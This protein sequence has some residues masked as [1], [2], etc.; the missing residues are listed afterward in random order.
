MR[1][2]RIASRKSDLALQQ[3]QWVMD[4]MK[5]VAP[6]SG[7]V[8]EVVP[9]VTKGDRILDVTLSKVGGKGLFVSEVEACLLN[10]EADMA[11]HSLKDVPADVAPGLQL[12][13]IP[14]RED[15]RDAWVSTSG[16][17]L[18]ELPAGSRVGTSSLRRVA[19]LKQVRPDLT[20]EPVRGNIG[21]RLGKMRDGQFDAI[22]LAAAGLHRMGWNDLVTAYLEP[23]VCIPAVG[24]AI[25]GVESRADDD[26]L[27][28][29]LAAMTDPGTAREATA[30]RTLLKRLN[31][32]CQVPIAGY[33]VTEKDGTLWLRGLVGNPNGDIVLRAE[34]RDKDP[35]AL[36]LRVADQLYKLGASELLA[37]AQEG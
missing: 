16:A 10:G 35:E 37:Q 22:V 27:N 28:R 3:T 31:G 13:A 30:E 8:L 6:D 19:Q 36:G 2:I 21:T 9:V 7:F 20:Y 12:S 4:K 32:S 24:Q 14:V 18:D 1:T 5:E 25:L 17:T 33:A 15:P 34:G 29:V 26:T 11:V 23:E